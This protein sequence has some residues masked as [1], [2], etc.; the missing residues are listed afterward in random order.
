[1][2]EWKNKEIDKQM[3]ELVMCTMHSELSELKESTFPFIYISHKKVTWNKIKTKYFS[4]KWN[5]ALNCFEIKVADY[6]WL[7]KI[8]FEAQLSEVKFRMLIS[9]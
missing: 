1:M 4:S 7:N 9:L 3:S 2:K 6:Y 5:D 8:S